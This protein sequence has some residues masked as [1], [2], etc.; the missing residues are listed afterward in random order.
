MQD[1]NIALNAKILVV[2]DDPLNIRNAVRILK[3]DYKV[4]YA[5]SGQAAIEQVEKDIPDLILL[6]IHMPNMNG[7]EVISSLKSNELYSE[8]PVIFLTAD[9]DQETEV[10]GLKAGALDFIAKPFKD[11]IVKQ[12][13]RH[14]LEL[15]ILQKDL[16]SEVERQTAKAEE[17]RKKMEEMSFQTVQALAGAIDAKDRYTKGHSSRVSEYAVM[18]ARKAGWSDKDLDDLKYA[19]LLHDVG[20]IG[21]P[22]VVLNKPGRLSD[23]E[24]NVIKSHTVIGGDILKN[25]TNVAYALEVARHHHERYDGKG[26]PDGLKGEDIPVMARITC[27]A[28]SYDAMNSKR[29]Y[30]NALPKDVIRQE[31]IKGRGTQFDPEYL[32]I[33]LEMFDKG[34]LDIEDKEETGSVTDNAAIIKRVFE[35]AYDIGASNQMDAL[36]GLPLRNHAENKIREKMV[37]KP[38]SIILIDLDNLKKLNDLFGHIEG[39]SILKALGKLLTNLDGVEVAARLGGDEFIVF[40][41]KDTSEKLKTVLDSLYDGFEAIKETNPNFKFNSLSCGICMTDTTDVYEDVCGNADKALYYA[42]RNGKGNYHYY[43][44]ESALLSENKDV[45]L[46]SL[47]N[48]FETAGNYN[49]AMQVDYRE[50][51]Q[52]FEYIKN[53]RS[54]Y[55]HDIQLVMVTLDAVELGTANIDKIGNA[56]T[57]MD[58]AIA[59]AI[60]TVDIYT[61]Y[62]S[63][64]FLIILVGS[65]KE[66]TPKVMERI[67]SNYYKTFDDMKVVPSY[68]VANI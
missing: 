39:D 42:K 57:A 30:R 49:G 1:N 56:I 44:R 40:T 41:T 34:E 11:D 8:I 28:D 48:S 22:D 6:D 53:M 59:N 45:D 50:F 33:F 65:T 46:Q 14:L 61:R 24:F 29:I 31:L 64:Q 51:T 18:L 3:D 36:T 38:G 9:T 7:F 16:K 63:M 10:Q 23:M 19:G 47:V 68:Q 62:T 52:I 21:V 54:R 20:K 27:I 60:R 5:T 17:R 2:D 43:E 58:G 25:I 32:D 26:Y 66:E 35:S 67:F 37:E 4:S 12:R 13:V 55:N 15:S